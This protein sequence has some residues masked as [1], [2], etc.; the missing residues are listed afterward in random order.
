MKDKTNES[1]LKDNP[2]F[3]MLNDSDDDVIYGSDYEEMPL[4]NGQAI[5]AKFKEESDSD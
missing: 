4:Q 1:Q 3:S 2:A 5:R